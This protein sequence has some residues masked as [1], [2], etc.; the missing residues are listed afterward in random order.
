M[1]KLQNMPQSGISK[2]LFIMERL[3]DPDTGCPWDITQTYASIAPYTIEEAY[4]VA[5][6]IERGDMGDLESELGDLL[7]QVV[8]HARIG[9]EAGDFSFESV[10]EA[11]STKMIERHPH[12]FGAEAGKT[13]EQQNR[14]WEA[15][16]ARERSA[17]GET[18]T[19]DGVAMGLPGLL[20]ALKLQKRL[21][22]VGF[23]W[24]NS[25]QVIAKIAEEAGELAEASAAMD[26]DAIEDEM[27][28][29]LFAMANLARHLGVD[30][31]AA[32]RRTNAKVTRRFGAVEDALAAEGRDV[33]AATL[34][35]MEAHWNTAK[36]REKS[37]NTAK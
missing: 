33:Q 36:Q 2:L 27:G 37:Q 25:Q 16:K 32:I 7:L 10:A 35:E 14:D 6:A 4:E 1:N 26:E 19:L 17:R 23:D 15:Q 11:I 5:D 24:E 18:R 9:E 3:R 34:D 21:A 31:E 8:F 28:D 29:L 12:V 20:R 30:P 13:V 22:R